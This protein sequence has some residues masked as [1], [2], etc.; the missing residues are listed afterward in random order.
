MDFNGGLAGIHFR[1]DLLVKTAGDD[2]REDPA[3][4]GSQR[5]QATLKLG[6]F[7]GAQASK[8]FLLKRRL[9]GIEQILVVERFDQEFHGSSLHGLNAHG[10]VAVG[11]DEDNR[12]PDVALVQ[13]TL[14]IDPANSRQP[15]VE[16]QTAREVGTVAG[17]KFSR[18]SEGF[19]W[20]VY[21]FQQ[22]PNGIAH[23]GI[24]IHN[25]NY[26]SNSFSC[27]SHVVV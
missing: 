3:L 13:L 24:I 21:R 2:Q 17:E 10:D 12:D 15:H 18:R 23:G 27:R 5:L 25:E 26:R 22:A 19:D 16:D 9:N 6:D 4:S 20:Q 1:G 8:W 11:S 14:K 7:G